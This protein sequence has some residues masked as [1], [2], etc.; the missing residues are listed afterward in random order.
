MSS[1]ERKIFHDFNPKP[2]KHWY[3]VDVVAF[4]EKQQRLNDKYGY[5]FAH[6]TIADNLSLSVEQKEKILATYDKDSIWYKRDIEGKRITAEG[7]IY[8]LFANN[9]ERYLIDAPPHIMLAA[10]GVDFGGSK[11]GQAFSCVGFT[12]GFKEVIILDEE[13]RTG[14]LDNPN[15]LA[16]AFVEFCKRNKSKYP[17]SSAFADSAEQILIRG[18][19]L[20]LMCERVGIQM[21][22]SLKIPIIDRI[23]LENMLFATDRIKIMRH[24]KTVREGFSNALWDDNADE[25]KRLDNFTS[26]IDILDATEYAMEAYASQ[27]NFGAKPHELMSL[28]EPLH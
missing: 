4:H 19:K 28:R 10:I 17:L 27:I 18:L 6:F 1:S 22:N 2:P 20:K 5:N 24:C 11:S 9:I 14:T 23:R 3:Y 21:N 13:Y 16:A 25:D 8:P 12:K 7:S 15:T 26:N